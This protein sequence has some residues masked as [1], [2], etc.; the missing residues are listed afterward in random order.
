MRPALKLGACDLCRQTPC[1]CLCNICGRKH[2]A[3]RC[4]AQAI[5]EYYGIFS[6]REPASERLPKASGM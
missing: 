1:V 3:C 5:L 4:S 6:G 2:E